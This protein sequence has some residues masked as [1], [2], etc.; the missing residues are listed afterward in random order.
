MRFQDQLT[1]QAE[2]RR[3]LRGGE[4]LLGTFLKFLTG[5]P[6]EILGALGWDFVIVDQEHAPFDRHRTDEAVLAARAAGIAALVRTPSA[7]AHAILGALDVGANGVIVPH[8]DTPAKAAAIVA[9]ARYANGQRGFA[10]AT[11]AANWGLLPRAEHL[12]QADDYV[13]VIA[14]IE[15]RDGLENVEAI[16]AVPGLDG[17][18]IG[19]G[20]LSVALGETDPGSPAM[21]EAS[22]RI[23]RAAARH[24]LSISA[25]AGSLD[26]VRLLEDQGIRVI[27]YASDQTLL[28]REAKRIKSA[29]DTMATAGAA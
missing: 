12:T 23:V 2:F 3:R 11:R 28:M 13:A 24:D 25:F 6:T 8:V 7:D 29:F 1:R 27:L 5:Q 19:Y 10:L 17:L 21:R 18:F 9:A 14:Q 22:A 16:A 4:R 15:D 20:D 26:D